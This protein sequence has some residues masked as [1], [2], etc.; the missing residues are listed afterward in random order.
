MWT[1]KFYNVSE[2][3]KNTLLNLIE[4][5]LKVAMA[6]SIKRIEAFREEGQKTI[7]VDL[8]KKYGQ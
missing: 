2:A 8:E 5:Y 7:K 6:N 4:T 3:E 1:K